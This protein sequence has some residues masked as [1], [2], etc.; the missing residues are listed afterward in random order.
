MPHEAESSGLATDQ[1]LRRIVQ[2]GEAGVVVAD[3]RIL[4]GG[5][6]EQRVE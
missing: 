3:A 4:V 5:S 6:V 2:V 1:D